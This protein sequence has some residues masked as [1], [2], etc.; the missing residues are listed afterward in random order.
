MAIDMDAAKAH[1]N[2]VGS[3]ADDALIGRL[4]DAAKAQI[5]ADLGF[6][7]PDDNKAIDQAAL[8]L[9]AHWY[10]NREASLVGVNAQSVPIG[11]TDI[12]NN[13]RNYSWA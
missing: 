5:A 9:V 1:L 2:I 4:I 7:Y 12:V 8:M 3:T 10:E 13:H 11:V 6:A